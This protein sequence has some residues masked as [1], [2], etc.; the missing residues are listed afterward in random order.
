MNRNAI[1]L[2]RILGVPIGL[3]YSWFLIF[4]LVT[5]SLA[6]SYFPAEFADWPVAQY[7]IVGAITALLM[8]ASV[9]LH[10]LGH[11]VV[12][13]FYKIPVRSIT[14]FIF[15]G[16]ARISAEPPSATAEFFIALAGPATSMALAVLF[17]LLQPLAGAFE[18][19]LA[20]FRY[21]AY[22]NASVAIF[23]LIPGFPLDGGR[24]FRAIVWAAS[25]NLRQ[26]TLIAAYLGRAIAYLLIAFGVWQLF[27]GQF[28]TGLWIAFVGW[29]LENAAS[30]Q[31][32]QQTLHDLLSGHRVADV[33]R[34][35]YVAVSPGSNLEQVMTEHFLTSGR[36]SLVVERE[37][38]VV[39][40][41]TAQAARKIPRM[42]WPTTT[43]TEAMIPTDLMKRIRPDAKLVDALL[44]MD[45][46]GVCQLPVMV[47]DTMQGLLGRDDV[48]GL[49]GTLGEFGPTAV[50]THSVR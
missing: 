48:I 24:V 31:I 29:F 25:H 5:W 40:L 33:M 41:L 42:A 49:L 36:R 2:G 3:D 17:G 14:L 45:R 50:A 12:A 26:A 27:V 6:S 44:A 1:P 7:W 8:F 34:R 21:L 43:V 18:P 28:G 20:V 32:Q 13:Q 39:G 22:I 30:A 9:V 10:E 15:G 11:A 46:D 38:K 35:D 47:G 4:G 16:V 19:L 37:K 23:N